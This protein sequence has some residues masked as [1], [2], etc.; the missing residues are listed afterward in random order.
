MPNKNHLPNINLRVFRRE[1]TD[2]SLIYNSS[3]LATLFGNNL[4]KPDVYINGNKLVAIVQKAQAK[5]AT[6]TDI[7]VFID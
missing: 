3:E 1:K 2:L 5:D 6:S 7:C 4:V